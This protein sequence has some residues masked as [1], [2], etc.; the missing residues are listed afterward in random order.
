MIHIRQYIDDLKRLIG[1]NHSFHLFNLSHEIFVASCR[2]QFA[3]TLINVTINRPRRH[4]PRGTVS[5]NMDPQWPVANDSDIALF[6]A[7][8]SERCFS[9]WTEK[10]FGAYG[11]VVYFILCFPITDEFYIFFSTSE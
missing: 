3:F 7:Y 6:S 8:E 9:N 1:K 4:F 10:S 2:L 11:G 5:T